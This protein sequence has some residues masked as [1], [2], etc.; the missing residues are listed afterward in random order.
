M[1]RS[2]FQLTLVLSIGRSHPRRG[3]EREKGSDTKRSVADHAGQIV[4]DVGDAAL[5]EK[6]AGK[7]GEDG[8]S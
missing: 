6:V 4:A 2:E 5:R 8:R 1:L 3:N 7:E